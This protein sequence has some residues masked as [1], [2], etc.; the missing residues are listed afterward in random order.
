MSRWAHFVG[1]Y[2]TRA[3]LISEAKE[4]GVNRAVSPN[5]AKS[6]CFGDVV[7]LCRKDRVTDKCLAFAEFR[8]DRISV[9]GDLG[10][11]V[12]A[13]LDSQGHVKSSDNEPCLMVRECGSYMV[14]SVSVIDAPLADVAQIAIDKSKEQ[15]EKPQVFIGGPLI[16]SYL[17]PV[18]VDFGFFRAFKRLSDGDIPKAVR[19]EHRAPM[20]LQQKTLAHI[21]DYAKRKRKKRRDI[22]GRLSGVSK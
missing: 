20:P 5:L 9:T 18:W 1:G 17:V 16:R 8:V 15:D 7:V 14:S 19:A 6:F 2:Y 11:E 3:K 4:S 22:Q 10:K 12:I 21:R 13:E